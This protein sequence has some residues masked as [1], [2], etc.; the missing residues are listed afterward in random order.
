MGL[1]DKIFPRQPTERDA[2]AYFKTLTAYQPV[3]TTYEGGLYEMALTRAAIAT[4]ARHASKLHLELVGDQRPDLAYTLAHQPNPWQDASKFLARLAT[5]YEIQNNAFVVPVE[6]DTGRV[7]GYYPVL[8]QQ[9]EVRDYDGVPYLRYRFCGGQTA[10]VEFERA[11]ML[12]QHQYDHDFF[13]RSNKPL[14]P[15]MQVAHTQDEGIVN[16]IKNASTIRFLARLGGTYK[17]K[18]IQ[19]A[20]ENFAAGNLQGNDTGLMMFDNKIAEVKQIESIAQVVNPKQQEYIRESVYQYFGINDKILTDSYNENEW[21]AYYEGKIEP[22]AIQ[23]SQVLS[24]MTFQSDALRQGSM[25]IATTNRLQYASNETKLN[26]VTQLFDRGF[27][28]HNQGREIFNLAPIEG[29]DKY[30]IRKEYSEVSKLDTDGGLPPPDPL[31]TK[32]E[33]ANNGNHPENA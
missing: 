30:F 32:K 24:R 15:T 33:E 4:F 27:L 3:Y 8:P 11:G 16:G 6:D 18:D 9:T 23:L 20:R 31:P 19:E 25:I 26:V 17:K 14:Y 1:F 5:I 7:T 10:A 22:F 2:R 28:T 12:V 21:D 13:G 29:G